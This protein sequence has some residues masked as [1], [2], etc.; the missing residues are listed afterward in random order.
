MQLGRDYVLPPGR[1]L[2]GRADLASDSVT[3]VGLDLED[4]DRIEGRHSN[5]IDWPPAEE[6][7][8]E[9]SI[10]LVDVSIFVPYS[11]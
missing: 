5:I 6:D 3:A 1:S 10:A 7:R 9:L 8:L 2:K 4:D 11:G